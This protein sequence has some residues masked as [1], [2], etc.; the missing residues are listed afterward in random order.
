MLLLSTVPV[1]HPNFSFR[2]N[3]TRISEAI[4]IA[5]GHWERL[6]IGFK[7]LV[8]NGG[9]LSGKSG[10]ISSGF[11][12][13]PDR[14][15]CWV[16]LPKFRMRRRFTTFTGGIYKSAKL[17][18]RCFYTFFSLYCYTW[19]RYA[20]EASYW[21]LS[22]SLEAQGQKTCWNCNWI[23]KYLSQKRIWKADIET[24]LFINNYYRLLKQTF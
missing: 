10:S 5:F 24:W 9:C 8:H 14:I 19:I 7:Q 3:R 4:S 23:C 2:G 13:A 20:S 17:Y 11:I 12:V 6:K 1:N 22:L 21:F 18:V 15:W 16:I